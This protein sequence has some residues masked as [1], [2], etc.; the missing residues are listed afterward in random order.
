[1]AERLSTTGQTILHYRVLEKL[2]SGGMGLV[3]KAEDTL[4]GRFVALKFLPDEVSRNPK[5]LE[6]FRREA[7][8]T[9]ALNHPHICTIHGIAEHDGQWFIVM[10]FLDGVTLKDRISGK[11]VEIDLLLPLAIEIADALDA[12]HEQGIIHRDVK[13]ANIFI[14]KRGHIK[15]LDFGLAKVLLPTNTAS[16][17]AAQ[18]TQTSP[19]LA[20]PD[21][22]SPGT[23]MGTIA[24]MSPEQARAKELDARTDLF[25]FGAV[26]Y[27]MAT[28]TLPFHG[29]TT[30]VLFDAILN[31]APVVP[32]RLNPDIPP[33]L[34]RII[35][36][37]LEKDRELRYQSAAEV[38]SELLRLKR[39]MEAS[40]AAASSGA[41]P[42]TQD[43]AALQAKDLPTTTSVYPAALDASPSSPGPM[44]VQSGLVRWK[45]PRVWVVSAVLAATV[46][47]AGL[48]FRLHHEKP[49]TEKGT[50]V[51]ADFTNTTGEAVFDDT[52][53]QGL[54]IQ[55]EQSPFL[56]LVSEQ[57]IRQTLRLMDQSPDARVTP[58]IARE[59][60]E[61]V[62]AT[63]E[64]EGSIASLGKE[65]VLSLK[66]SNCV[67]GTSLAKV[68]V[69]ADNKEHV[70]KALG[71][72]A[73]DLRRK[74]GE[75]LSTIEKFDTPIEQATTPSLEA[76]QAY[77]LGRRMMVITG[78]YLAA[79]PLFQR[80]IEADPNFAMAYAAL[81]TAYNNLGES[82]SAAENSKHSF[83]LRERVS[84]REKYYIESHYYHFATG[85]LEEARKV[86][87][88]WA[89]TYPVDFTPATNLGIIHRHLG[90]YEK[91]LFEA[92][93]RLRLD[94]VG[95]QGPAN[96]VAGYIS[97]NRLA[98]ATAMARQ[99]EAR[100]LESPFLKICEYQLAFLQNDVA[101]MAKRAAWF[102]SRSE[103]E[104]GLQANQSDTAAYSGLLAQ[105]REL[106]HRAVMSALNAKKRETAA[107]FEAA[108][109]LREA[110]FGNA[111]QARQRAEA[112]LS[113][114]TGKESLFGAGMALALTKTTTQAQKIAD[115]M[116]R[117]FPKNTVVQFNYLPTLRAQLALD[118]NNAG[119]AIEV[120][121][122]A[123]PYEL[124]LPGD[125]SF[126]PAMYPVYVRGEAYLTANQGSAAAVEF[127]KILSLRAVVVN[128]PIGALAALGL[129]HAYL[130]Q[131]DTANARAAYQN[132]LV[133]WENAD[134]DIPVLKEAK[135]EFAKL[136]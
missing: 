46:L 32:A 69:T 129:A 30:A 16:Q 7:R 128:E 83:D 74:L 112:A 45:H 25:S 57:S 50:I 15:I 28:G 49:V 48:Y 58:A 26:L 67:T 119:Q 56:S 107:N 118:R 3:Y 12:A 13:P 1:M 38:R 93:E 135:T 66:T 100:S 97:L 103:A 105:A 81:G 114:S 27:E 71:D 9:S 14:T 125:G 43:T 136:H 94:P 130:L 5:S 11:P 24:Y 62:K 33:E 78:D 123:V 6:R 17:I 120:L 39:H 110:L 51:L 92:Q 109:A 53:K 44:R 134:S 116:A 101:G 124:G 98:E 65:Y 68:Q 84:E 20:Q 63:A 91:S 55:L 121:Q 126:T 82:T 34:E 75:S 29:D 79:V 127:Q 35:T 96:V 47:I 10:E 104:D 70:L 73:T 76:L 95:A 59:L 86:Y 108:A 89:Q 99:A 122:K 36:R 23:S 72:G 85:D 2:G 42:P 18:K 113:L 106:S 133:L 21:P 117:L 77:S 115:D 87:E 41:A 131:G 19:D 37:A 132:F 40:H 102:A 8:A 52:L 22:T 31:Q 60:C 80:A 88:L 54:A 4:L 111:E 90:N 61:R 64:L